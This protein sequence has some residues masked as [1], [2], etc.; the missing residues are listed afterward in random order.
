MAEWTEQ[1]DIA[2]S[3]DELAV[4][5]RNREQRRGIAAASTPGKS[6]R[7]LKPPLKDSPTAA[8]NH[9]DGSAGSNDAT[10]FERKLDRAESA[11]DVWA[12]MI[13]NGLRTIAS[14]T[15]P[16]LAESEHPSTLH[17]TAMAEAPPRRSPSMPHTRLPRRLTTR[18]VPLR[19]DETSLVADSSIPAQLRERPSSAPSVAAAAAAAQWTAESAV[20]LPQASPHRPRWSTEWSSSGIE[21]P[22]SS[23]PSA[24]RSPAGSHLRRR[25]VGRARAVGRHRARPED[26]PPAVETSPFGHRSDSSGSQY[27]ESHS[28][29]P[30]H[31]GNVGEPRRQ[32]RRA[33]GAEAVAGAPRVSRSARGLLASGRAGAVGAGRPSLAELD[34]GLGAALWATAGLPLSTAGEAAGPWQA[35]GAAET[36]SVA[37][38]EELVLTLCGNLQEHSGIRVSAIRR[39]A[40]QRLWKVLVGWAS[41]QQTMSGSLGSAGEGEGEGEEEQD[42]DGGMTLAGLLPQR[43]AVGV[44]AALRALVGEWSTLRVAGSLPEEEAAAVADSCADAFEEACVSAGCARA[45]AVDD[46]EI[47]GPERG[48]N[49]TGGIAASNRW[50]LARTHLLLPRGVSPTQALTSVCM[51]LLDAEESDAAARLLAACLMTSPA[52]RW[53]FAQARQ[54]MLSVALA[55]ELLGRGTEG[56]VRAAARCVDVVAAACQGSEEAALQA[57]G[58]PLPAAAA[59]SGTAEHSAEGHEDQEGDGSRVIPVCEGILAAVASRFGAEDGASSGDEA[60][61][62]TL[63]GPGG[64]SVAE[65]GVEGR[66]SSWTGEGRLRW[67]T[68]TAWAAHLVARSLAR[69]SEVSDA[70]RDEVA[71]SHLSSLVPLVDV[72]GRGFTGA[73]LALLARHKQDSTG[74]PDCSTEAA[75]AA[76]GRLPN[77]AR[78]RS[79][80]R[81]TGATTGGAHSSSRSRGRSRSRSA[82]RRRQRTRPTAYYGAVHCARLVASLCSGGGGVTAVDVVSGRAPQ[83]HRPDRHAAGQAIQRALAR[84]GAAAWLV[85]LLAAVRERVSLRMEA[86]GRAVSDA[87]VV[88][89][90]ICGLLVPLPVV[91]TEP[92]V[93]VAPAAL[94]P[95]SHDTVAILGA[96]VSQLEDLLSWADEMGSEDLGAI[97]AAARALLDPSSE[98]SRAASAYAGVSANAPRLQP[99]EPPR[100]QLVDGGVLVAGNVGPSTNG[101]DAGEHTDGHVLPAELA[102]LTSPVNRGTVAT[103]HFT[104]RANETEAAA[105]PNPVS[106]DVS[107]SV[108]LTSPASGPRISDSGALVRPQVTGLSLDRALGTAETAW[109]PE[110]AFRAS[111]TLPDDIDEPEDI[112]VPVHTPAAVP[113]RPVGAA[114]AWGAAQ[115]ASCPRQ[116]QSPGLDSR[117][118]PRRAVSAAAFMRRHPPA[119]APSFPPPTP[120]IP[121]PLHPALPTDLHPGPLVTDAGRDVPSVASAGDPS[122]PPP[123]ITSAKDSA[124]QLTVAAATS[125]RVSDWSAA[126]ASRDGSADPQIGHDH[127][128]ELRIEDDDLSSAMLQNHDVPDSASAYAATLAVDSRAREATQRRFTAAAEIF[129]TVR[130][131]AGEAAAA[132]VMVELFGRGAASAAAAYAAQPAPSQR[133]CDGTAGGPGTATILPGDQ[134]GETALRWEN[135]GRLVD[136]AAKAGPKSGAMAAEEL[137]GAEAAVSEPV[138]ARGDKSELW[139]N[140]KMR[141]CCFGLFEWVE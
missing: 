40:G 69:L 42:D 130:K 72:A 108:M 127:R 78:A 113:P 58:A 102:A 126:F 101:L 134:G 29:W 28:S 123:S 140:G 53:C 135:A 90:G 25:G 16:S 30:A 89:L 60:L 125:A 62:A 94:A 61:A 97:V 71:G 45:V 99:L 93:A 18:S 92:G 37:A 129:Q 13:G 64:A 24:G 48:G 109:L 120:T 83:T 34:R 4:A 84:R 23:K 91:S 46:D 10:E 114:A 131:V 137:Q 103:T 95:A 76:A 50:R 20:P 67:N 122:S 106:G 2:D 19:T 14:P 115:T 88:L 8:S 41:H 21:P 57:L 17:L 77:A 33:Q 128:N 104:H 12:E 74:G 38:L 6:S 66:G 132:Q 141:S 47:S 9:G 1:I 79:R 56:G 52:T 32:R 81:A 43:V 3:S 96:Q 44:C 31:G 65:S 73:L 36:E 107:C 138:V 133:G 112:E 39:G 85:Q 15:L 111:Q 110:P 68:P 7:P 22:A 86:R 136:G 87:T 119:N 51:L 80:G 35:L 54:V 139:R 116:P 70:V 63:A 121:S 49:N 59:A 5:A 105:L 98:G 26:D 124:V 11:V 117:G 75:P 100:R 27:E 118:S 55:S 82:E